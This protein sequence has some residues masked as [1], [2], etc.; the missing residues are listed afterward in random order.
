[1][2][3]WSTFV[4][5]IEAIFRNK[6]RSLLTMLGVVIGVASVIM[7]VQLGRATSAT[8]ARQITD[9]GT[10]LLMVMPGIE[11]RGLAP[12]P[13]A[14]DA[15]RIADVRAIADQLPGNVVAPTASTRQTVVLGSGSYG[16]TITGATNELLEA[17]AMTIAQG[18]A[19]E[20]REMTGAPVCILGQTI[21]DE[22]YTAAGTTPLGSTLRVG[23]TPCRVIGI[24]RAKGQSLGMNQDDL[25][26]M[27]LAAVQRRLVG[28]EE[29]TT[30]YV[31]VR[32]GS[33]ATTKTQLEHLLR[34]RRGIRVGN[35]D[36]FYV[37][38]MQ[39]LAAALASTT[40]ALTAL[41][42]AIAAVSLVVGGIGIMN[43]MLVSV[44]ERTREIGVR[45]AIGA[46]GREVLLQFLVEAVML[47]LLGGILGVALG[48]GATLLA[49]VHLEMPIDVAP[50]VIALSFGVAAAIGIIFGLV[51][52]RKAARLDPI[53]ALRHE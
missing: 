11:T 13:S 45:L 8:V 5:A 35:E 10:N 30:I 1:M 22:L 50:D 25:V 16:T 15:F 29:V 36:D 42:S 21:V 51:P 43:I 27:P 48:V 52:A 9:M 46:R 7:M 28:N 18:R 47:S 44:T 24:L 39:E 6:V 4:L 37:R 26:L 23:K 3:V 14:A 40:A 20:P 38:D 32:D 2:I 19:F 12:T 34:R 41:L 31:S 49:A 33:T 17:R 53:D